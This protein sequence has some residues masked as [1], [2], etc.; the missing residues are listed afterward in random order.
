M[1]NLLTCGHID[2]SHTN[3]DMFG[4]MTSNLRGQDSRLHYPIFFITSNAFYVYIF[5]YH[6]MTEYHLWPILLI[7]LFL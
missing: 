1:S 5:L 7:V 3:C 6:V 4:I 2:F